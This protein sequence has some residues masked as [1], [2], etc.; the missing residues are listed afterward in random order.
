[1]NQCIFVHKYSIKSI[2]NIVHKSLLRIFLHWKYTS[3]RRIQSNRSQ[4]KKKS[5]ILDTLEEKNNTPMTQREYKRS[6]SLNRS[7]VIESSP[8]QTSV[9]LYNH[10]QEIE[11]HKNEIRK[12]LVPEYSFTPKLSSGTQK[13]LNSKTKKEFKVPEEEIA[14]V[15]GSK[16]LNFTQFSPNFK[17]YIEKKI[18]NPEKNKTT[19]AK[20]RITTSRLDRKS[21]IIPALY[22]SPEKNGK[23]F[24]KSSGKL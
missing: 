10:A 1:M 2:R 4:V 13:W 8:N 11:N 15:S 16:L 22:P 5:L 24:H 9:R 6:P 17:E 14:V 23:I 19:Q 20:T 18:E 21:D 7:T 12:A 3:K